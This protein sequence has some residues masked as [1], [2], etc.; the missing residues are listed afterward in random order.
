M[1]STGERGEWVREWRLALL[2]LGV[3]QGNSLHEDTE[4]VR[5]GRCA[6]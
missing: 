1:I 3:E 5:C 4:G 6:G 2:L